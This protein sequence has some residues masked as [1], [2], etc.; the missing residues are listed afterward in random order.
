MTTL[1]SGLAPGPTLPK[2]TAPAFA[3]KGLRHYFTRVCDARARAG[4][5]AWVMSGKFGMLAA[6]AALMLLLAQRLE[7]ALYG[8]FVTLI[9]GQ[10]LL[11][12]VLLPGIECGVTRLRTLPRYQAREPELLRAGLHVICGLSALAATGALIICGIWE[13]LGEPHWWIW[14]TAAVVGG[15]LGT[16]LVDY[17][18]SLHL[19]RLHYRQATF[20][21]SGTALL[22]LLAVAPVVLWWPQQTWLIFLLYPLLTLLAGLTQTWLLRLRP[23][24]GW[25][26]PLIRALLRY[27]GWQA[28]TNFAAVLSLYQGTFVLNFY[29]QPAAT[30]L[31]G[32]GLTLSQGFFALNN[33]YTEYL[34]P[35]AVRAVHLRELRSFLR[36]TLFGSLL[37]ML[38]G[39]LATLVLGQLIRLLKPEL[40]AVAPI[41]YCLAAA[42]LLLPFQSPLSAALHYLLRPQLLTCGWVLLVLCTGS[43]SLWLAPSRGAWGAALGQLGGTVLALL[44]MA[45]LLV[46]AWRTAQRAEGAQQRAQAPVTPLPLES[47][48]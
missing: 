41:F 2:A 1:P 14:L 7:L 20:A 37:L 9:S 34:L 30:G 8:R 31:F 17:S 48:T 45:L 6:N 24:A 33:A 44:L 18:Y 5:L 22:R 16:A 10:L 40:H 46:L 28:L 13:A 4:E 35:R 38:G 47:E 36:R 25:D 12:R 29:G 26:R 21:Q 15:A 27:S 3:S 42:L 19:A 11:S 23:G 32:L 39:L 43:L